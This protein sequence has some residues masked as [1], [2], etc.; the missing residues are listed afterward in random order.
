MYL[1]GRSDYE[2]QAISM[3]HSTSLFKKYSKVVAL[4]SSVKHNILT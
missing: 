3:H 2:I 1:R 4:R